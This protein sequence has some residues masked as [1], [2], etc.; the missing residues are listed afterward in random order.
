MSKE[1]FLPKGGS[2]RLVSKHHDYELHM[3]RQS[4]QHNIR[5]YELSHTDRSL[6][7]KRGQM[8]LTFLVKRYL[9]YIDNNEAT[10]LSLVQ[11]N[12]RFAYVKEDEMLRLVCHK[13]SEIT[14]NYAMP[15]RAVFL[16]KVGLDVL[17]NVFLFR[18]R[19][20]SRSHNRHCIVLRYKCNTWLVLIPSLY[21]S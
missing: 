17:R 11:A 15:S 7:R 4:L 16:I 14:A 8:S 20:Q 6:K 19:L 21:R 18:V 10:Y 13:S 2:P 5:R 3:S 9:Q 12:C 1:H